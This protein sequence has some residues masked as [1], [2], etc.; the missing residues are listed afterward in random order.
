MSEAGDLLGFAS[1]LLAVT[2]AALWFRRVFAVRIP[3]DRTA[4]VA[5]FGAAV[6]LGIASFV[7]GN[8]TLGAVAAGIGVGIGGFMAATRAISRQ[9]EKV[10]AVSVGGPIIDFTAPDDNGA[11]VELAGLRG[12]PFLLK[13]FRGHW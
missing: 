10:P 12:R 2:T 11:P 13:F 5:A 6:V 8:E 4:W 3:D 9:S 7:A 1:L